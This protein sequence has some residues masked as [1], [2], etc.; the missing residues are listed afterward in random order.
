VNATVA[1]LSVGTLGVPAML[2]AGLASSAHCA[3]MCGALF[4]AP[5]RAIDASRLFGRLL[6]YTTIGALA[7]GAGAWVLEAGAWSGMGQGVRLMLLPVMV[8]WLVR[9]VRARRARSCCAADGRAPGRAG[10]ARR[11]AAG[12][13]AALLPCPLLL[14]AAGYAMLSGGAMPGAALLLAF[15]VGT[16]PAVQSGAWM[17]ARAAALPIRG[18]VLVAGASAAA[19]LAALGAPALIGWC[20]T[21]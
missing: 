18:T 6:A 14:A 4:A 10:H 16:T 12:F 1:A 11:I 19:L 15:G 20:V 8:W 3:L 2:V 7:G 5:G 9:S 21:P 13:A 17:W